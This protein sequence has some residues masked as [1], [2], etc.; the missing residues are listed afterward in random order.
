MFRLYPLLISCGPVK[1]NMGINT[2]G[3]LAIC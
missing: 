1:I 3:S 2:D